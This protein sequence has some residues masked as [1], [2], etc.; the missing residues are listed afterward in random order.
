MGSIGVAGGGGA[1]N[2]DLI[3]KSAILPVAGITTKKD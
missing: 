2:D 1:E 3:A